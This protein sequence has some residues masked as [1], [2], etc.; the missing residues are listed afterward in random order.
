[1]RKLVTLLGA[2]GASVGAFA[3]DGSDAIDIT[4]ANTAMTSMSTAL[5]S[6]VTS[7]TP[8]VVAVIGAFFV[9]PLI[10]LGAKILLRAGKRGS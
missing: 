6:W 9:I 1:M 4:A 8:I 10:F 2:V 3:A 7:N 5:K